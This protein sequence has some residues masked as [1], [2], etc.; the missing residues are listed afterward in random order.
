MKEYE[1]RLHRADG[2][3]SIVMKTVA[4]DDSDARSCASR[5]LSG[6]IETIDLLNADEQIGRVQRRYGLG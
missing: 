3:L 1:L 2:T 4:L 5:M 6:D